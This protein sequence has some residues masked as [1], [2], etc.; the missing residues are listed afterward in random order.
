MIRAAAKNYQDVAVVVSPADY[1]RHPRR[2]ARRRAALS[3]AT[4]WRLAKKAFRTTADYDAAI[5]ARLEREDAPGPLPLD[6]S[7]ARA[8]S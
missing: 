3:I 1:A 6:L 7:S 2:T 4:A 5:S 8:A